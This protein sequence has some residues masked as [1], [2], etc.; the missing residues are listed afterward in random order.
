MISKQFLTNGEHGKLRYF[1]YLT[2]FTILG[3]ILTFIFSIPFSFV[4]SVLGHFVWGKFSK[5][6]DWHEENI[7]FLTKG[8]GQGG[9]GR[10][11]LNTS[12]EL[13]LAQE[14]SPINR[15]TQSSF[16]TT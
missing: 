14:W 2:D 8:R 1:F 13:E 15:A 12:K 9:G 10:Q 3:Q 16:G 5:P 11:F 6:D 4:T 7:T